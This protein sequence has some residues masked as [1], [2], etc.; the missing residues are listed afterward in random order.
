MKKILS[1]LL[2]LAF[3]FALAGCTTDN[4]GNETSSPE[5][6]VSETPAGF[7]NAGSGHSITSTSAF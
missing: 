3:V 5:P 7:R 6:T 4:A 1:L 2:V